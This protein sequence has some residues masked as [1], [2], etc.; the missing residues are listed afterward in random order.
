[1]TE[2]LEVLVLFVMLSIAAVFVQLGLSQGSVYLQAADPF[3]G[4]GGIQMGNTVPCDVIAA[5]HPRC[6]GVLAI[7]H[8]EAP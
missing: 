3:R 8:Q 7:W 2:R 6:F 5:P 4:T 1:M